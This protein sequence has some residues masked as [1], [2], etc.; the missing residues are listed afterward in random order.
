MRILFDQGVPIPLRVYL[1]PHDVETAYEKGWSELRNGELLSAAEADAFEVFLTTDQNLRYEQNL[2]DRSVAVVIL[3]TTSW[4]R[5]KLVTDA[6]L[7]AIESAHC[8]Q[9]TVVDIPRR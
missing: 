9:F 6:V 1:S 5:I 8:D 4:P 3:S 7:A 2:S